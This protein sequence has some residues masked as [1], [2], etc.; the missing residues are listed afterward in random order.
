MLIFKLL[1]Y[2][3]KVIV[4]YFYWL[5]RLTQ[6]KGINKARLEFPVIVE[7]KG[8]LR[9]GENAII[10][11]GTELG[12]G[13]RSV[14]TFGNS[15]K[16]GSKTILKI[17]KD[18]TLQ[19]GNH[20]EINADCEIYV[21]NNW[22]IGNNVS[23]AKRCAIF[24]REKDFFG[25]LHIHDGVRIGDNAIIDLSDHVILHENVGMGPN[26]VIYTHGHIKTENS[27]L[28]IWKDQV[29]NG[30]VEINENVYIGTNVIILPGVSIGNNSII[31]A[32]SVVNKSVPDN[33]L[34]G[35]IPAKR[36]KSIL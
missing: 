5:Y 14:T 13:E 8:T 34:W 23:I 22:E 1:F 30:P 36:I 19:I 17:A 9:F 6:I 4:R 15:F 32:G 10:E 26:C 12:L 16:L 18:K 28:P 25:S 29:K 27:H 24:S 20:S 35:G 21:N 2:W 11:K 7:G 3:L 33:E 31:A